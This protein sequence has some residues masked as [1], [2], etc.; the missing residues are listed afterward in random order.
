MLKEVIQR[1]K[2]NYMNGAQ[3]T[4]RAPVLFILQCE[5]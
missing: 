4:A 5:K 3:Q 1:R 2:N